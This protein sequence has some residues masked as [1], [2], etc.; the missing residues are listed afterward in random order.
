[1]VVDTLGWAGLSFFIG[2]RE[3]LSREKVPTI[4]KYS[5][6][7]FQKCILHTFIQRFITYFCCD[8]NFTSFFLLECAERS[9]LIIHKSIFIWPNYN[10]LFSMKFC[11]FVYVAR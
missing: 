9:L 2:E 8:R 3:E 4:I 1:M 6:D 5:P 11:T 7:E 10:F